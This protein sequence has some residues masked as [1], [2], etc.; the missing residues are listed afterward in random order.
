M[1]YAISRGGS[2]WREFFVKE[3]ES[4]DQLEDHLEWI[5][6]SGISWY[7]DG[8]FYT[9]Y[10]QPEEGDELKGANMNARIYYHR[11]G[12]P[13]SEDLLIHQDEAH[14]EW[15]F[16]LSVTEDENYMVLTVTEST[17]GNAIAFRKSGLGETAFTWLDKDFDND[18]TLVGSKDQMLYLLTNY[19]AP[20]YKLIGIDVSKP[21][22]ANWL[23]IIPEHGKQVLES[24]NLAGGKF[25]ATYV[26][27]AYHVAS[28]YEL[29]GSPLHE[30]SLP[31]IGSLGGFSTKT[32]KDSMWHRRCLIP[33]RSHD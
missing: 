31:G 3:I 23:D 10:P 22:P 25:I 7:K 5:K 33:R 8:F 20:R 17:S 1:A 27:D 28:V 14:P 29:D 26:K 11:I 21:D 6:F 16:G 9:R 12:T 2:D 19:Q 32:Q 18:F 4:G 15:G 30:V 13:Q 24:V